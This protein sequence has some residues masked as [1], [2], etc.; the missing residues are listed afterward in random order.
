MVEPRGPSVFS[1]CPGQSYFSKAMSQ[2]GNADRYVV[3]ERSIGRFPA[4]VADVSQSIISLIQTQP[5]THP[6]LIFPYSILPSPVLPYFVLLCLSVCVRVCVTVWYW[7]NVVQCR[8]GHWVFMWS[9]NGIPPPFKSLSQIQYQLVKPQALTELAYIQCEQQRRVRALPVIGPN[10]AQRGLP[11]VT[12]AL[13]WLSL[14][15]TG[16]L[17]VTRRH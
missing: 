3:R 2:P 9:L 15:P 12:H 8:Q 6:L 4:D 17:C 16:A 13:Y 7:R 11:W 10:E 1:E 5:A 14:A